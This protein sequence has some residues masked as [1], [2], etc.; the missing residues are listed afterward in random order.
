VILTDDF[1]KQ[2]LNNKNSLKIKNLH[3]ESI[4]KLYVALTRSS[5]DTYLMSS[6]LYREA[7]SSLID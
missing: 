2:L 3:K 1:S 5:S 6:Y 4:H 7:I